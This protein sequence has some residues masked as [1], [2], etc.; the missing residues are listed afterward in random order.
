[1]YRRLLLLAVLGLSL[2][3]CVPYYEGGSGYYSSEVYSAPAPAYYY[4]GGSSYYSTGRSYYSPRYYQPAPRYYPAP[5]VE[6]RPY[7]HQGWGGHNRPN[8]WGN[9]DWGG[10]GGR[11][12]H[13]RGDHGRGDRGRGH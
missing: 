13:D 5:R 11:D 10:H 7:P 12:N 3:A 1:M 6:Y 8:N 2:S 9:Q 4:G